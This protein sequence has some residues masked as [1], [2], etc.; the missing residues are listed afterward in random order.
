M[1][2]DLS[3]DILRA[4]ALIA[5]VFV[6]V[7]PSE[8]A[9][10]F[11]DFNVCLIV[12]LSGVS[13]SISTYGGGY[14]IFCIKRLKRIVA[15]TWIFLTVWYVCLISFFIYQGR[16]L[17]FNWRDM[18]SNYALMTGWYVWVMRVFL[19]TSLVSPLVYKIKKRTANCN[20]ILLGISLLILVIY[21]FW[22]VDYENSFLYY[23]TMCIP[24]LSIF[25]LGYSVFS[26]SDME[27]KLW[28]VIFIT[29]AIVY[30]ILVYLSHGHFVNTNNYKTPPLLYYSSF[31]IGV[32]FWL[33]HWKDAIAK[34]SQ[35]LKLQKTLTFLGSHTIWFYF[36]H[37][38]IVIFINTLSMPV[39][40]KF[41]IVLV[42]ATVVTYIYAKFVQILISRVKNEN[43]RKNLSLIFMG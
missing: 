35:R 28:G 22:H 42:F 32:S 21:E 36:I 29:I 18:L 38:P 24:Y 20:W 5:I 37:I 13:F 34:F 40:F 14:K 16:L 33:W 41:F 4:I 27:V 43:I 10:Q 9:W 17:Q 7:Y 30:G 31:G 11:A 8:I 23:V 25:I 2:R 15:P 3:I 12:F 1:P 19:L 26:F 6:H 39:V